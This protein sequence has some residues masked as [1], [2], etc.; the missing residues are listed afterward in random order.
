[1][2][3]ELPDSIRTAV[4]KNLS[5]GDFSKAKAIHDQYLAQNV[6]NDSNNYE[7]NPLASCL[8]AE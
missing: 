7:L 6:I 4:I 2:I 3:S 5:S 8:I 1:M